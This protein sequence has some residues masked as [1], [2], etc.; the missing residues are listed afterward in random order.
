MHSDFLADLLTVLPSSRASIWHV[1]KFGGQVRWGKKKKKKNITKE[2]FQKRKKKKITLFRHSSSTCDAVRGRT[3]LI[4]GCVA[5][6]WWKIYSCFAPER[7]LVWGNQSYFGAREQLRSEVSPRC[8]KHLLGVSQVDLFF[9][10]DSEKTR[11]FWTKP[12]ILQTYSQMFN[13]FWS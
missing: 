4:Y 11:S 1:E 12:F 9:K 6:V 13:Q 7:L 2:E 5:R 10:V 8:Q 3:E